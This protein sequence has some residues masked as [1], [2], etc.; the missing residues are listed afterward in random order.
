MPFPPVNS[1]G[2]IEAMNWAGITRHAPRFPPVNS[3]GLIEAN[4]CADS[5]AFTV[6]S[7]PPVNSGGL[8]EARHDAAATPRRRRGC[9]RR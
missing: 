7:F 3:G 9:F 8:I 1:G 5:I 2:L 6:S 4:C